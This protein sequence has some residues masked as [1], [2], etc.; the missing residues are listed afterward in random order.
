M[1]RLPSFEILGKEEKINGYSSVLLSLL[2]RIKNNFQVE[3]PE[4]S[5]ESSDT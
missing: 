5:Y 3:N 2:L 4:L 1:R